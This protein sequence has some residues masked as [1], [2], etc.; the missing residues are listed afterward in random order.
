MVKF[1]QQQAMVFKIG[2]VGHMH[3]KWSDTQIR[4]VVHKKIPQGLILLGF[5]HCFCQDYSLVWDVTHIFYHIVVFCFFFYIYISH[6]W[7]VLPPGRNP[8][9]P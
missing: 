9:T 5:L 2:I 6:S 1:K 8:T 3:I 4:M 7:F